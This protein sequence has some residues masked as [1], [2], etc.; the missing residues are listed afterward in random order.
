MARRDIQRT[1]AIA[2]AHKADAAWRFHVK[3]CATCTGALRDGYPG[4][5]CDEGWPLASQEARTRVTLDN[6][7]AARKRPPAD[8][9]LAMF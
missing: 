3:Q 2:A 1:I 6:L 5:I 7:R 8:E 9:Q 4:H